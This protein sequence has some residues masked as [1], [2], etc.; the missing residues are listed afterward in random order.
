MTIVGAYVMTLCCDAPGCIEYKRVTCDAET[1]RAALKGARS[2]GWIVNTKSG[3]V[4]C[5]AHKNY[6]QYV[7]NAEARAQAEGHENVEENQDGG[8]S[9]E[10]APSEGDDD[11]GSSSPV[12]A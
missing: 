3:R 12:P 7:T 4:L 6:R 8:D 5:P 11:R 10:G 9:K 1:K 2:S